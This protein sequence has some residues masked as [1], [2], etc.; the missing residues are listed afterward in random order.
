MLL[1]HSA[2]L[3]SDAEDKPHHEVFFIVASIVGVA[4]LVALFVSPVIQKRMMGDVR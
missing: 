3:R 1:Q 2:H 4:G